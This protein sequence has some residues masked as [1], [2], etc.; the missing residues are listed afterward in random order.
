MISPQQ[1]E[2][3]SSSIIPSENLFDVDTLRS[4]QFPIR[5]S[6]TLS[7]VIENSTH[8]STNNSTSS[9]CIEKVVEYN[10]DIQSS[11]TAS[12]AYSTDFLS[13]TNSNQYSLTREIS[14]SESDLLTSLDRKI[15]KKIADNQSESD[16]TDDLL[17]LEW[18]QE[19]NLSQD[20][21]NSLRREIRVL[22]QERLD[23]QTQ[24]KHISDDQAKI[25]LLKKSL[26]EKNSVI[27]QLQNEYELIK[28]KNNNSLRKVSLVESDNKSYVNVIDELK[29]NLADLTVDL[30]NQIL[31]KR[32]LE[33]SINNLES[34][35]QLI[36][37]E[38]IKLTNDIKE[39]QYNK[40]EL[41]TLL[42]KAN[43][44]VAEQGSTIE[45]LRSENVQV[46]SQLS[47][48]QRRMLH[49]KQQIMDYLRQIENDLIE[50]ERIKQRESL[51]REDYEQ[52]KHSIYHDQQRLEHVQKEYS[53]L[54]K[55]KDDEKLHLELQL[56][57][58]KSGIER[59]YSHFNLNIDSIDQI[60]P[61]L[62][63]RYQSV[64]AS[65]NSCP[66]TSK[67]DDKYNQFRTNVEQLTIQ[68]KQLDEANCAWQQF[69]QTQLDNFKNEFQ[70][71]L[72]I[73]KNLTLDEIAQ[74]ILD[75]LN[76]VVSER[77][78]LMRNLDKIEKMNSN[79]TTMH[80]L[81]Q[82]QDLDSELP[83]TYST[84]Q[85]HVISSEN[86]SIQSDVLSLNSCEVKNF[87]LRL[88]SEINLET[89]KES[90]TN[91]INELTQ[92]LVIVKEE[93]NQ[94]INVLSASSNEITIDRN[95]SGIKNN[96]LWQQIIIEIFRNELEDYLSMDIDVSFDKIIKQIVDQIKREREGFH[97]RYQK[98]E[99]TNNR[100]QSELDSNME[101]I[102]QSYLNIVNEYNQKLLVIK[103]ECES[104]RQINKELVVAN[105]NLNR[106]LNDRS[107]VVGHHSAL[108]T[109]FVEQQ[110]LFE[111]NEQSETQD[112]YTQYERKEGNH[113]GTETIPLDYKTCHQQIQAE[114][115]SELDSFSDDENNQLNAY[116][117]DIS[118]LSSI[119]LSNALNRECQQFLL[120]KNLK[121]NS[122]LNL[123]LN[124]LAL[125]TI[126][127]LYNQHLCDNAKE[128]YNETVVRALKQEY[129]LLNSER[130][131]SIEKINS[132]QEQLQHMDDERCNS[133]ELIK[134]LNKN[135]EKLNSELKQIEYYYE[136]LEKEYNRIGRENEL[137]RDLNT[138]IYQERSRGENK[139]DCINDQS[140]ST[141]ADNSTHS[142]IDSQQNSTAQISSQKK[143]AEE[144]DSNIQSL[145]L[146]EPNILNIHIDRETQT[147]N[148]RQDTLLQ[149]NNKLKHALQTIKEKIHKV[150]VEQSD[151]FRDS[152]DNTIERLD[153]LISTI[154][155]QKEQIDL[156]KT[157]NEDSQYEIK[158]L[159]S[160][161]EA[162]R[163]QRDDEDS[164]EV[165]L[166]EDY[167]KQIDQ[168]Q[169]NILTKDQEKHLLEKRLQEIE[170]E[171]KKT[172]ED[173]LSTMTKFKQFGREH[174]TLV[175]QHILQSTEYR[176]EI[177]QLQEKLKGVNEK[178]L[179]QVELHED[180]EKQKNERIN[181]LENHIKNL[182]Q[183]RIELRQYEKLFQVNNKLKR[184][185]Q[186]FKEKIHRLADDKPSLFE[187][188]SEEISERFNHLISKVENQ[189][190]QIDAM[191]IERQQADEK[192]KQQIKEL[193]RSLET[194]QNE[195]QYERQ[196]RA[197]QLV[198]AAT[199]TMLSEDISLS[200]NENYQK[201][202]DQLQRQLFEK[203]EEQTLSNEHRN[204]VELELKT[205]IK[206]HELTMVKYKEKVLALVEE[207]NQFIE[208]QEIS[209]T[210]HQN[211]MVQ[212]TECNNLMRHEIDELKE[213]TE[214][215]QHVTSQTLEEM[216]ILQ[217]LIEE[218]C[219]LLAHQIDS[220][221]KLQVD[222]E[223]Q[224][225]YNEELSNEYKNEIETLTKER[226]N[227][228]QELE[229]KTL[230]TIST[231]NNE[232]QT[233]DDQYE[234]L[235]IVK[236]KVKQIAN[237]R[238]HLFDGVSQETNDRVEHLI[239][240]VENQIIQ[241]NQLEQKLSQNYVEQGVFQER[242]NKVE[243]E[244]QQTLMKK[245]EVLLQ[246]RDVL[247]EQQSRRLTE[248]QR[249]MELLSN[250]SV[251]CQ[252]VEIQTD[253]DIKVLYE[254]LND[255]NE[256][257][258]TLESQI[259]SQD[260]VKSKKK[261]I[262]E[263][264]NEY[265][266]HIDNL[267]IER[268]TLL[269]SIEKNS[270]PF[271]QFIDY[272]IQT[273]DDQHEELI[274]INSKL[275]DTIESIN[276]KFQNIVATRPD[277]FE[278]IS[279]E[280][281]ERLD[282]LISTIENQARLL[283]KLQTERDENA[284]KSQS[285]MS[286]LKDSFGIYRQQIDDEYRVKLDEYIPSPSPITHEIETQTS[287]YSN[288]EDTSISTE[289]IRFFE[290]IES[291]DNEINTWFD[292][293]PV[294]IDKDEI[295][296]QEFHDIDI[297]YTWIPSALPEQLTNEIRSFE[298]QL[299]ADCSTQTDVDTV[300]VEEI[301][302]IKDKILEINFER[303]A[304]L[305]TSN[306]NIL[307][308]LDK[309][310]LFIECLQ[311]DIKEINSSFGTYR[312]RIEEENF[313]TMNQSKLYESNHVGTQTLGLSIV[314]EHQKKIENLQ[315]N[316]LVYQHEIG[317][318]IEERDQA[319]NFITQCN[320]KDTQ[321][322]NNYE[323]SFQSQ[324]Q[325][326]DEQISQF[327]E[328]LQQ[329]D[330]NSSISLNSIS[331]QTNCDV[332]SKNESCISE[333]QSQ[334]D[335]LLHERSVLMKKLNEQM[336]Q[337]SK[338]DVETQ[339]IKD[340]DMLSSSDQ[341]IS[342]QMFEKEM[343]AWAKE[344]DQLKSFVKQIQ[345]ENKKLKD[346]I[347][348]FERMILDYVHENDRLKQE[349]RQLS[350]INYSS[351]Q[352]IDEKENSNEDVC[353]L[354]LKWLTYEVAQRASNININEQSLLLIQDSERDFKQELTGHELQLQ[355]IRIQNKRLKSQLESCTMHFKHIQN[356]MKLQIAEMSAIKEETERLR[357]NEIQYPLEIDRLQTELKYDQL[358]IQQ[359]E[360]E[361]ADMKL[362]QSRI[363]NTSVDSLREL[364]E[365]K[366][367]E[368]NA[369]K[370]KFDFTKQTHE[371]ELQEAI[372][373]NQFSL[374]HIKRFEQMNLCQQEK[375]F[376]LEKKLAKFRSIV[377]P[378]ID[379]EQLFTKN[380][381]INI[382]ELQK[383]ITDIDN[384]KQ[385][386]SSLEPIRDCLSLLEAQMKD[387]HH[388][389]I[390]NH[391]R[392]SRK[393]KY[394]LG[395]ECLSCES[396]WE[397][398]H[399]IRDL[400]EA[401]LDP[402]RFIESSLVEPMT[403]CSCPIMIDFVEGDVRLCLED[404][405]NEVIVK[406]TV[407]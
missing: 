293:T 32:R 18:D 185:V 106:Q 342:H 91:T 365:L 371:V 57:N 35:C 287:D 294:I 89:I 268:Q 381:I 344:S 262:E 158:E 338:V 208:Q 227:L 355:K 68:C 370:E 276:D 118:Y 315:Q 125:I 192:S 218:K 56:N 30:Q 304:L 22:L 386:V 301:Q 189:S 282:N 28:E 345:I 280:T 71:Y 391:A 243:I 254:Q 120:K 348:K 283:V 5:S 182:K 378:L 209:S 14:L 259:E 41:E 27:E 139:K 114:S 349:N 373:A 297:Q 64:Q 356:E 183:E 127:F 261:E 67:I 168:F 388:S 163:Y 135:N 398:T 33:I 308:N 179:S 48:M 93:L 341:S 272:E 181:E 90:Y 92:E 88:E 175:E 357:I 172:S 84:K 281:N 400:Q 289:G 298:S 96:S 221:A 362:K 1:N 316:E 37:A 124:H 392:R 290:T 107:I 239:S 15:N 302:Q 11:Q 154:R 343:L 278:D 399:D 12:S 380:P 76:Q 141:S 222:I 346:I 248:S 6:Q 40:Q 253:E 178:L 374:N 19:R 376:D 305:S 188:I 251:D 402:T 407:P 82:K 36:D 8:I 101:S 299:S 318:L 29:Q 26:E 264:L 217:V 143:P 240:I 52:L 81:D 223:D 235:E 25:D 186:T 220:N 54:L 173:Q 406:A 216:N 59:L 354:T 95:N 205:I 230:S 393:W 234:T 160:S 53:Q 110:N 150:I 311:T 122:S 397:V 146:E 58:C 359:L 43:V 21:I 129:H 46:R 337:P 206:N 389:I 238:P 266:N 360:R 47:T 97:E 334:I 137:L 187:G 277:L 103:D 151:L 156:L 256:K 207:R 136:Q 204:E 358:K 196:V 296:H 241:I 210:Q 63:D 321:K 9:T 51:L 347:L 275:K 140:I 353:F 340:T 336:L 211:Q 319:R 366:E 325:E 395:F 379:H 45:M 257:L 229:Q 130:N 375:Q 177:Q 170:F 295:E 142:D 317:R 263:Q 327:N 291:N 382:D 350:L 226:S 332:D 10:T 44:Q 405:L 49:E 174:D 231:S 123:E 367:R 194:Y 312:N 279:E 117:N 246:E 86:E 79:H 329:Q 193:E 201:Q 385:V 228:V 320:E 383:L 55:I 85:T 232:C 105:E 39:S 195:L 363:D 153:H 171:L 176:Q 24:Y 339:T 102:R 288:L 233:N 34:N 161:L 147:D 166:F 197:E 180:V 333:Y 109:S 165:V 16:I 260:A 162:Y 307:E 292:A 245:Y 322:R 78:V 330:H 87:Q 157:K 324:I 313:I 70:N 202:I 116:I 38:R 351:N 369:L 331:S 2:Q 219:L 121:L 94:Q 361:L 148:Q 20:Y 60:I 144:N 73:E 111:N 133:H 184:I 323:T 80:E 131:D 42:Q 273:D 4:Q 247:I 65:Q 252:H 132:L 199:P 23:Y 328:K 126:N 214:R 50:K 314:E 13:L 98:L 159:Q 115:F 61:I 74:L 99:T 112:K 364:L 108:E 190:T 387:L 72:S 310:K 236:E 169:Q 167:R 300:K 213:S 62:E 403:G 225:I 255:L 242:L 265:K 66:T 83:S 258:L 203:D 191:Q 113:I 224:R 119:D 69:Q 303:S 75:Y 100:L 377:Q 286:D 155:Q 352:D 250:R 200:I 394:K 149:I 77:D 269:E 368:L 215:H 309:I 244:L 138:K 396:R 284:E 271:I 31:I 249:D 104:F 128:L 152:S 164:T 335:S 198:F 7:T 401:C 285:V 3:E 404:L 372:K 134:N 145:S 267:M 270:K 306:E 212:M 274:Q 17:F 384:E 390:Q 237:E 326:R